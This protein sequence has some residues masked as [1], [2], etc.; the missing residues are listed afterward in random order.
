ML[1]LWSMMYRSSWL[2]CVVH[3]GTAIASFANIDN[4]VTVTKLSLITIREMH[5]NIVVAV[6]DQKRYPLTRQ[7]PC[8]SFALEPFDGVCDIM[9]KLSVRKGSSRG[10]VYDRWGLEIMFCYC[11]EK[12]KPWQRRCHTDQGVPWEM[13]A[14]A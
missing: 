2:G 4:K 1:S 14:I 7:C 13:A 3:S 11:L 6:L 5:T 8:T 10:V 9:C 12:R